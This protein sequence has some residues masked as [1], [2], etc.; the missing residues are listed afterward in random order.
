MK[1]LP[2]LA[3]LAL[4]ATLNIAGHNA[5]IVFNELAT[6][7]TAE[8]MTL[9]AVPGGLELIGVLAADDVRVPGYNLTLNELHDHVKNLTTRFVNNQEAIDQRAA[10]LTNLA[11]NIASL[12]PS[13]P[14]P[15]HPPYSL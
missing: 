3:P 5:R 2:F 15:A 10:R 9:R 7:V 13:P 12:M 6:N 8:P 4:G 1:A 14:P 11:A